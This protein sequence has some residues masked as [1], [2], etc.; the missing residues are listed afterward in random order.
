MKLYASEDEAYQIRIGHE[1]V[2]AY[3]EI[4]K[5]ARGVRTTHRLQTHKRVLV[6]REVPVKI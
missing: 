2:A 5:P 6:A 1:I 3:P 4:Y